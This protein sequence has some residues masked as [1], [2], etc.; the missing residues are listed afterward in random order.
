MLSSLRS[1]RTDEGKPSGEDLRHD[2]IPVNDAL[3]MEVLQ[4]QKNLTSVKL[5]LSKREL[6][7]LDMQHEITSADVFHDEVDS[8]LRLETGVKFEQEWVTFLS[9]GQEDT[10]FGLSTGGGWR[11]QRKSRL[12]CKSDSPFNFIVFNDEFLLQNLD[13]PQLLRLLLLC[14]HYLSEITRPRSQSHPS[15]LFA[16]VLVVSQGPRLV[17]R[18]RVLEKLAART[19]LS[20]LPWA[21]ER[22]AGGLEVDSRKLT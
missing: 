9:G 12:I 19:A 13:S 10:L 4:C 18:A 3:A 17:E 6:L 2:D 14:Q 7:L 1:L 20:A 15:R 8:G 5:G 22:S 21:A 11:D 16:L